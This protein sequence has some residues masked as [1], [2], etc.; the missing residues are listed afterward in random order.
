LIDKAAL[1]GMK[2]TGIVINTSRGAVIH[3]K[4]LAEALHNGTIGGAGLDVFEQEPRVEPTLLTAPNCTF[5]PH[6]GSATV[7]TRRRMAMMSAENLLAVLEG[8][9]PPNCV[10]PEVLKSPGN[11]N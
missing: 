9:H 3:E 4:A 8:R 11:S 2:P 6:I 5:L 7:T 1:A 10:N